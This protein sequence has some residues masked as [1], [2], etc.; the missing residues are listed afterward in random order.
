MTDDVNR[1]VQCGRDSCEIQADVPPARAGDGV[2]ALR[3]GVD[4]EPRSGC[5][6]PRMHTFGRP[7]IRSECS[8]GG[9]CDTGC[10]I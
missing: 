6:G 2:R 8:S 5:A 9:S 10:D 7:G 3:D 1:W 4:G